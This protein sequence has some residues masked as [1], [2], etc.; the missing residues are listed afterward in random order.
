MAEQSAQQVLFSYSGKVQDF[1]GV[2][3]PPPAGRRSP[4]CLVR[5]WHS[6]PV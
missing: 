1:R 2:G 6:V 3:P 5:P 4:L